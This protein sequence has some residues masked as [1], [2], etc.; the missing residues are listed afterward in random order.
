MSDWPPPGVEWFYHDDWSC[1]AHGDCLEILPALPRAD[2]VL[3]DPLRNGSKTKPLRSSH[4]AAYPDSPRAVL[5][6]P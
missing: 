6:A 1:I 2:L 4:L 5:S 3:T